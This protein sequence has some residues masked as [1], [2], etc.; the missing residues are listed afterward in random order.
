MWLDT[1]DLCHE[2]CGGQV[3]GPSLGQA[4][5]FSQG[6]D[7]WNR[8]G[9]GGGLILAKDPFCI[10]PPGATQAPGDSPALSPRFQA[11]KFHPQTFLPLAFLSLPICPFSL[12]LFFKL[13]KFGFSSD[14]VDW[15]ILGEFLTAGEHS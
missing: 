2:I 14:S 12:F 13:E 8:A 10:L 1:G 4:I 5:F 11:G 6:S 7:A 15:W 3:W 9:T